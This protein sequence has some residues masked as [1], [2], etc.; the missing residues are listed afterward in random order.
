MSV[1]GEFAGVGMLVLEVARRDALL[2][3][4]EVRVLLART[5]QKIA[6]LQV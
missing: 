3:T 4:Q 1:S 5:P 6:I 2:R